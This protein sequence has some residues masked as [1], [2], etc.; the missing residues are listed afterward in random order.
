MR[1]LSDEL[2]HGHLVALRWPA[3][4]QEARRLANLGVPRLLLVQEGA[5]PPVRLFVGE[6]WVALSAT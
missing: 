4:A 6:R 2:S 3:E 1:D 5:E